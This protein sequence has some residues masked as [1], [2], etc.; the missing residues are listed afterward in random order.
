M[1]LP[2]YALILMTVIIFMIGIT[3]AII[4][5]TIININNVS[6]QAG[7]AIVKQINDKL[8]SIHAASQK[9][10]NA[11]GNISAHQR[12]QILDQFTNASAHGGFATHTDL[13]RLSAVLLGGNTT[14]H[15][16]AAS[17][18]LDSAKTSHEILKLLENGTKNVSK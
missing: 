15:S 5:Y 12:N 11:Q 4:E 6:Q 3:W 17:A 9:L 2:R 8:D 18:A 10:I 1:D 16:L 14:K 13:M 7:N